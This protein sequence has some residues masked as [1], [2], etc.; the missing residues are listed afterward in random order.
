MFLSLIWSKVS[1]S[2]PLPCE[3]NGVQLLRWLD[4]PGHY[5]SPSE[6]ELCILKYKNI[7]FLKV[8]IQYMDLSLLNN[9]LLL[10]RRKIILNIEVYLMDKLVDH[11]A[12]LKCTCLWVNKGNGKRRLASDL[13]KCMV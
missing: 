10:K 5:L 4:G 2:T 3:D 13:G 8:Q 9:S 11:L 7:N 12:S 6:K 1:C